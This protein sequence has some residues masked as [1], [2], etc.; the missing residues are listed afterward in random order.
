VERSEGLKCEVN[1]IEL[2]LRRKGYD[3]FSNFAC[4]LLH[5]VPQLT[6]AT[7]EEF[8]AHVYGA[9]MTTPCGES[10]VVKMII[11]MLLGSS[12]DI[13]GHVQKPVDKL[14]CIPES[15]NQNNISIEVFHVTPFGL[16]ARFEN[17]S[18]TLLQGI[19]KWFGQFGSQMFI[20]RKFALY[21]RNFIEPTNQNAQ[22]TSAILDTLRS[23]I[24]ALLSS[25]EEALCDFEQKVLEL[26]LSERKAKLHTHFE[27]NRRITLIALYQRCLPWQS[28]FQSLAGI[29]CSTMPVSALPSLTPTALEPSSQDQTPTK[30]TTS[31]YS[32]NLAHTPASSPVDAVFEKLIV[33]GILQDVG[34]MLALGGLVDIHPSMRLLTQGIN[35]SRNKSGYIATEVSVPKHGYTDCASP[36]R[37]SHH[38]RDVSLTLQLPSLHRSGFYLY[39]KLFFSA[40]LEKYLTNLV[41]MV[42]QQQKPQNL[43][44]KDKDY[45][46]MSYSVYD[47]PTTRRSLTSV[48]NTPDESNKTH[49]THPESTFKTIFTTPMGNK[50]HK[51][52]DLGAIDGVLQMLTVFGRSSF[53]SN[54]N[55]MN[56]GTGNTLA[57]RQKQRRVVALLQQTRTLLFC[58]CWYFSTLCFIINGCLLLFLFDQRVIV[59][60][61]NVA[62]HRPP[63]CL[64]ICSLFIFQAI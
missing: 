54:I 45:D 21:S 40:M 52:K 19:L 59:A 3:S 61:L 5:F 56:R 6:M 20:C 23:S 51:A 38:I 25:V 2:Q 53:Q 24:S 8:R 36:I 4:L 16:H 46:N 26:P 17:L 41:S 35:S 34:E 55:K 62:S 47:T 57:V 44:S 33:R 9:D 63:Y 39:A 37:L 31:A 28:M 32:T 18:P 64:H 13:F 49:L 11:E 50:T 7:L 14:Y 42:W 12:N 1:Q 15:N 27:Y 22:L 30:Q 10:D 60:R 48:V 29:V 43:T 58:T